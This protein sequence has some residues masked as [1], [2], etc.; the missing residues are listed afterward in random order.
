MHPGELGIEEND[1]LVRQLN[2]GIAAIGNE[3]SN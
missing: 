1:A 3:F 2:R